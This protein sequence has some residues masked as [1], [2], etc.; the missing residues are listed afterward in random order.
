MIQLKWNNLR[1]LFLATIILLLAGCAPSVKVRSDADPSVDFSQYR[2]YNFFSQLGIEGDSYAS[3]MGQH[4]REA[5]NAQLSARGFELSD[6]PQLQVN[7]S[8]ASDDKIRVNS[9][10]EPYLYGGYYGRGYRAGW[11]MPMYYGGGTSTTVTQYTQA[12]VYV[13][14]VDAR[15]H[16]MVW[17][18][19]ATFK[20]TEKMQKELRQSIFNTVDAVFSHFPVAAPAAN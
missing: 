18:G 14:M 5:I 17:Q 19:V 20:V 4:F 1:V 11:G 8:A 13:D 16:E 15:R 9:Y 10:Q 3:L 12:D 6:T 7:V 2:T